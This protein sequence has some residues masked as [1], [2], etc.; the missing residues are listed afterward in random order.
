MRNDFILW[1]FSTSPQWE[2]VCTHNPPH[3][4][5]CLTLFL[6]CL[7]DR[8]EYTLLR[9]L[10]ACTVKPFLSVNSTLAW[11]FSP[12]SCFGSHGASP[13][14]FCLLWWLQQKK[15]GLCCTLLSGSITWTLTPLRGP[16]SYRADVA[17]LPVC[18]CPFTTSR[19][20]YGSVSIG[21]P[22]AS[23]MVQCWVPS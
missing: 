10:A 11:L 18:L 19:P 13:L 5:G 17:L 20:V 3:Y 9:K 2:S 14:S 15:S 4:G 16:G 6:H 8:V 12:A 23:A 1:L 22:I 7:F 21:I